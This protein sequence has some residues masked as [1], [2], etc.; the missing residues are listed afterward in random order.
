MLVYHL[1]IGIV[2]V[3]VKFNGNINFR[4]LGDKMG[5]ELYPY[6]D[7][8]WLSQAS[9]HS[10]LEQTKKKKSEK[11]GQESKGTFQRA[12]RRK[13]QKDGKEVMERWM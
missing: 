13:W 12:G 9:T 4:I 5:C 7:A 11:K 6:L 8:T 3:I 10:E 1:D 2:V